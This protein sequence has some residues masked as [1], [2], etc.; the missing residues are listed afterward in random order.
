[1]RGVDQHLLA[2]WRDWMVLSIKAYE[3]TKK[4]SWAKAA[5]S[6]FPY[7]LKCKPRKT[8]LL[9]SPIIGMFKELANDDGIVANLTSSL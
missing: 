7:A 2:L 9:L 8:R 5:I 6:V 3:K 4:I 1:L